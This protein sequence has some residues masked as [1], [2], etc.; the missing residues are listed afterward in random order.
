MSDH[1][2]REKKQR[3]QSHGKQRQASNRKTNFRPAGFFAYVV[4]VVLTVFFFAR[5]E[6]C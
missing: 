4:F 2:R 1:E 5:R 3:K 6:D